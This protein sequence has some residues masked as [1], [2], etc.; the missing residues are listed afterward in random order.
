MSIAAE[1]LVERGQRLAWLTIG[2]NTVEGIVAIAS[3][4]AA[5]SIALIGFG[6]DSYV[7]VFAGAVIVWRLSK[8]ARGRHFSEQAERRAVKLI[9]ATFIVLAAGVGI[10]SVR[11]LVS[12]ERAHESIAGIALTIVS[13]IVMPILARAKRRVGRKLGDRAV[14]S[15][16]DRNDCRLWLS[17]IVLTGLVLNSLFGW[18]WADPLAGFGIISPV[19]GHEAHPRTLGKQNGN[20]RLL[21]GLDTALRERGTS[22][23]TRS[24]RSDM[25]F[26]QEQLLPRFQDKVMGSKRNRPIRARVCE[27][28]HGAVVEVGFGT[29]LNTWYYPPEVTKV[30]AIEPSH[31]CMRIA[32][33]RI[34][35]TSVPVENGGLT[36]EHLDL[37]SGEFDAVLSTWTLCTIPNLDAAL[38]RCDV[39]SSL[40]G[41]STSWNTATRRTRRLPACRSAWNRSTNASRVAAI[42]HAISRRSSHAPVST[43]T[44]STPTTSRANPNRWDTP[45]K[46]EQLA[47]DPP[48]HRERRT[49]GRVA[50]IR[51]RRCQPASTASIEERRSA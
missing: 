36:G 22:L 7:E 6:V 31:V 50:L 5:G 34:A 46:A 33:P 35:K 28:L 43:S 8:E 29:G 19:A 14:R 23:T 16:R 3:G 49:C 13:L 17:A 39:S 48:S 47:A 41:H 25:G 4:I 32:E 38:G 26:Y 21:V 10:E 30:V 27:G 24:N 20:R 51:I 37:P 42:S 40:T 2:W 18:W 1:R 44:S 12:G 11:K 45:T 15:G 9:A